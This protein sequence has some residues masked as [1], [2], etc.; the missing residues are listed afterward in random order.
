[1]NLIAM[2][3]IYLF[4]M[5][6]MRRT[7]VQSVVS[8]VMTTALYFIVFGTA[9]GSRIEAI[10]GVTYGAF[11]IP[12]LI[13]LQVMTLCTGNGSFGIYFPKFTGTVYEIFSAPISQFEI[14]VGF[15]GA[16]ATKGI[17]VGLIILSTAWFFVDFTVAHPFMIETVWDSVR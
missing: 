6:R 7:L 16:A 9:I 11:I 3:S 17:I 13:M 15:V 2:K 1:M 4:E 5:E 10:D 12:G 14:V 8:P